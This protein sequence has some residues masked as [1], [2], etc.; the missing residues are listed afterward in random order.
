MPQRQPEPL[1]IHELAMLAD[2]A[3]TEA[4]KLPSGLVRS[5]ALKKASQLRIAADKQGIRFARRGR[6]SLT[7]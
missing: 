7:K 3:L 6:P 5:E 2:E 1:D 4:L